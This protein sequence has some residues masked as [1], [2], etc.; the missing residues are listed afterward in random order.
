MTSSLNE[1]QKLCWKKF[2]I[3]NNKSFFLLFFLFRKKQRQSFSKVIKHCTSSY[4]YNSGTEN[5]KNIYIRREYMHLISLDNNL[6]SQFLKFTEFP[7]FFLLVPQYTFFFYEPKYQEWNKSL[8]FELFFFIMLSPLW[9]I[10]NQF[11]ESC[12]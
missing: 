4:F 12:H 1:I 5:T 6:L 3:A 7:L 10:F 2:R 11:S 9:T 8:Y